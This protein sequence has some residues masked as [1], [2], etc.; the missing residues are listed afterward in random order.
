VGP[1]P[2]PSERGTRGQP[3]GP[4]WSLLILS[5]RHIG[6]LGDCKVYPIWPDHLVPGWCLRMH[7]GRHLRDLG[8]R[9]VYPILRP[10]HSITGSRGCP[11]RLWRRIQLT[12]KSI[13]SY[14]LSLRKPPLS[15]RQRG[16]PLC[17]SKL[18]LPQRL[19]A[20]GAASHM[21]AA[22]SCPEK[23]RVKLPHSYW[24]PGALPIC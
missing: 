20:P 12:H 21:E 1:K 3:G 2:A 23:F 15:L 24:I 18:C 17:G 13:P 4:L 9:K 8:D 6:D 19:T 16:G 14:P 5:S 11:R 7:D 22:I 10:G